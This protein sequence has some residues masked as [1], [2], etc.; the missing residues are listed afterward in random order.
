MS[1]LNSPCKLKKPISKS[2]LAMVNVSNYR[3]VSYKLR[4][5]LSQ[6]NG[7]VFSVVLARLRAKQGM[8]KSIGMTKL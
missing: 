4:W 3:E 1:F 7:T 8:A 5:V 6:I 2:G